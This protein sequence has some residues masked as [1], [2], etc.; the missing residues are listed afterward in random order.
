MAWLRR[1][2]P[3]QLPAPGAAAIPEPGTLAFVGLDADGDAMSD[4]KDFGWLKHLQAEVPYPQASYGRV[5][6]PGTP[7]EL[8]ERLT[9]CHRAL[10]EAVSLAASRGQPPEGDIEPEWFVVLADQLVPLMCWYV[11]LGLP[12]TSVAIPQG[13][14]DL[15][16]RV[17]K[18][19]LHLFEGRVGDSLEN[20]R[21]QLER[22]KSRHAEMQ[23]ANLAIWRVQLEAVLRPLVDRERGAVTV[24]FEFPAVGARIADLVPPP[25]PGS[26]THGNVARVLV[27]ALSVALSAPLPGVSPS[28][29]T[30]FSRGAHLQ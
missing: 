8:R 1:R 6:P 7:A 11:G 21:E 24:G 28:D 29:P 15:V 3:P 9:E 10:H 20:F 14:I 2:P 27:P 26:P 5:E 30:T 13:L 22:S 25:S 4:L 17:K 19:P 18:L 12:P 16:Q 23:A